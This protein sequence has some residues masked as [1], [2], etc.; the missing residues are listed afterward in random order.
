VLLAAGVP[1][2]FLGK[3][4]AA[5]GSCYVD[6]DNVGG[7]RQ[8][9]EHLYANGRR[10]IAAV[11]GFPHVRHGVDRF[12]GY[13]KGLAAVGLDEDP[14]L[15]VEADFTEAGGYAATVELIARGVPFDALFAASD[16]TAQGAIR[17]LRG[18]KLR[19]PRDVAVV[20]F[21][22]EPESSRTRPALS[23]VAQST[24]RMG[25]ELARLMVTAIEDPSVRRKV[26]VPT[27]LVVRGTS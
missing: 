18:A 24:V 17:A 1:L 15:I 13:Q 23:T 3:P 27:E 19:V 20:G 22:D 2:V 8:A 11:T 26:V 6:A 5:R 12:A 4:F 14:R 10:R 9:V 16:L 25:R 7:A 21:G